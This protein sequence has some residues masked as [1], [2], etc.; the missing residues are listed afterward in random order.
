V[1]PD[2]LLEELDPLWR[3]AEEHRHLADRDYTATHTPY[4][5]FFLF[6]RGNG[7]IW[8]WPDPREASPL[9]LHDGQRVDCRPVCLLINPEKKIPPWFLGHIGKRYSSPPEIRIWQ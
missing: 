7:L 5:S 8:K 6:S 2:V 3:L 9:K 1:P 4:R